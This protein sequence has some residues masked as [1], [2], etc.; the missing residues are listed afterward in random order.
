M[1]KEFLAKDPESEV[2]YSCGNLHMT[3]MEV[4]VEKIQKIDYQGG[5]K[6]TPSRCGWKKKFSD[7]LGQATLLVLAAGMIVLCSTG[8]IDPLDF[9]MNVRDGFFEV[10][11]EEEGD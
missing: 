7:S 10:V 5:L 2:L 6:A 8:L 9:L 4:A 1:E 3:E 11:I